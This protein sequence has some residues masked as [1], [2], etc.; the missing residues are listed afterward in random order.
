MSG[1]GEED[2]VSLPGVDEKAL[3][4]DV[5]ILVGGATNCRRAGNKDAILGKQLASSHFSKRAKVHQGARPH[6]EAACEGDADAEAAEREGEREGKRERADRDGD[7]DGEH[8]V[9]SDDVDEQSSDNEDDKKLLGANTVANAKAK[10]SE[11]GKPR[12]GRWAAE[13]HKKFLQG[14]KL[15]GRQWAKLADFIGTRT[16]AQVRSHAQK[17]EKK[18]RK[19]RE[20]EKLL[21][22]YKAWANGS[23][24]RGRRTNAPLVQGGGD[25][26]QGWKVTPS[27]AH[28]VMQLQPG[29]PMYPH[30]LAQPAAP[31]MYDSYPAGYG[32]P[33]AM[34]HQ[35]A[36]PAAYQGA[37]PA[38]YPGAQPA[39][40]SRQ[41]IQ[42]MQHPQVHGVDVSLNLATPAATFDQASQEQAYYSGASASAG[43]HQVAV[44]QSTPQWYH[45]Q[46]TPQWHEPLQH[47][48]YVPHQQFM[49]APTQQP[50]NVHQCNFDA[51]TQ[52]SQATE[53]ADQGQ[54]SSGDSWNEDVEDT[55][56]YYFGEDH[57]YGIQ[58]HCHRQLNLP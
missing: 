51:S 26:V 3:E 45:L 49:P 30:A 22:D 18:V 25:N 44:P 47:H 21:K 14:E 13:E 10:E 20:A 57:P 35:G 31:G 50:L 33:Q 29:A 12:V 11:P 2:S 40:D 37:P 16:V 7:E 15:F 54:E 8:D 46:K 38:A 6:A 9:T 39:Y 56:E 41:F 32:P 43:V 48:Q 4:D 27:A 58:G 5:T 23:V 34:P 28:P 17:Y 52:Y 55:L 1:A 19:V 36:P 53:I 24:E 42:P